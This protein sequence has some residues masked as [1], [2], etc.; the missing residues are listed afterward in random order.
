M[1]LETFSIGFSLE[2]ANRE[3]QFAVTRLQF[4]VDSTSSF[5]QVFVVWWHHVVFR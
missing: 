3:R 2:T 5:N 1:A 4:H